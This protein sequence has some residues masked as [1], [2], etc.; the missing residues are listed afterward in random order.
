MVINIR[1]FTGNVP[2]MMASEDIYRP[3]RVLLIVN[4]SLSVI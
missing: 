2:G 3:D 1:I 4:T